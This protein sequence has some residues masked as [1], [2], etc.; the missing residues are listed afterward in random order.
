VRVGQ[1][2]PALVLPALADGSP[3]PP[4]PGT[5]G[6]LRRWSRPTQRV[7]VR[8]RVIERIGIVKAPTQRRPRPT[9]R[10]RRHGNVETPSG[11]NLRCGVVQSG[12]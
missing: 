9:S 1:P 7:G 12:V 3:T 5:R 2:F 10:D 4:P 11:E 6:T 8:V